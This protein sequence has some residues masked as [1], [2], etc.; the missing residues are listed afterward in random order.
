MSLVQ[1][2]G[3][4]RTVTRTERSVQIKLA[5]KLNA[6]E[7]QKNLEGLYEV[8]APG[9]CVSKLSPRT[10]IIKERNRPE[11]RVKKLEEKFG[12]KEER[13]T[14]LAENTDRRQPKLTEKTLEEKIA[15]HKRDLKRKRIGDQKIDI[16]EIHRWRKQ[17]FR[18][19]DHI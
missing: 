16:N 13:G 7:R 11:V 8:L 10:T 2:G 4:T 14:Q 12:T 17:N 5:R 9:T 3:K 6:N 18:K 1:C 15:A 19:I